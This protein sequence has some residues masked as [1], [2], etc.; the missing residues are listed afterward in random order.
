[1]DGDSKMTTPRQC[2]SCT[3]CCT[4]LEVTELKKPQRTSCSHLCESGCSIYKKRPGSCR[5]FEC[6]WINGNLSVEGADPELLR[7][8][9]FGLMFSIMYGTAFGDVLAAWEVRPNA[10]A[11]PE[12]RRL[13]EALSAQRIVMV[14]SP[15]SRTIIGPRSEMERIKVIMDERK[16]WI[17][18]QRDSGEKG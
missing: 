1:M 8:D 6:E 7:P 3:Q 11:E 13:L 9:R 17:N 16:L 10:S 14:M 12:P 5:A 15:T 4:I 2:G 18:R